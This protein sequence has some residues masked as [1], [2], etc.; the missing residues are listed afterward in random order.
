MNIEEEE[1]IIEDLI[2]MDIIEAGL[3]PIIIMEGLISQDKDMVLG[4]EEDLGEDLVKEEDI[5]L[6]EDMLS[7]ELNIIN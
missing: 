1:E 5:K 2:I 4:E 7:I 6:F 3:I